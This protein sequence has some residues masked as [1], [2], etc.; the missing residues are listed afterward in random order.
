M[1]HGLTYFLLPTPLDRLPFLPSYLELPVEAFNGWSPDRVTKWV[2][3]NGI[4]T[5]DIAGPRESKCLGIHGR[6]LEFLRV[7]LKTSVVADAVLSRGD[8]R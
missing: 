4:D 3:A 1:E 2:Q 7:A 5:L 8:P 6:A